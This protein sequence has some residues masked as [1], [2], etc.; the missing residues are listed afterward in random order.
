MSLPTATGT[1]S[2]PD[3]SLAP[4]GTSSVVEPSRPASV[5]SPHPRKAATLELEWR[6]PA[7]VF[8]ERH[9]R[10]LVAVLLL[11]GVAL[12]FFP[13]L[14]GSAYYSPEQSGFH[15][16]EPKLVRWMDDLPESFTS[17][18]DYR[19]P[20][21]L[22]IAFGALWLPTR[23]ALGLD[24]SG[25]S[26]VGEESY[27]AAQVFGR[28]LNVLVFGLGGVLLIWSFTRRRYGAGPAVL[29]LAA[30]STM[31]LPV[32][33]SALMLPDIAAAVLLFA[34]F[35]QLARV[36]ARED[37][38]MRGFLFAGALL[39]AATA[40]K[41]TSAIGAIGVLAVLVSEV[42][43]RRLSRTQA[44][45]VGL[46]SG[47]C[48]LG[49]FLLF[50][51]GVWLDPEAFFASISYEFRSKLVTSQ[52]RLENLPSS[53]LRSFPAPLMA[54]AVLGLVRARR[55]S[56]VP[57]G[58]RSVALLSAGA[59][60]SIYLLISLRSFRPDYVLPLFPFVAVFAGVGLWQLV[61]IPTRG[62]GTLAV[63][64]GLVLGLVQTATWVEQRY[65]RDTRYVFEEWVS[66]NLP[67]GPIGI[68][69][70]AT[71][72]SSGA[73][74]PAGYSYVD[75]RSFPEYIVVFQRRADQ[76]LEFLEDPEALRQKTERVWGPQRALAE[77]VT[78]PGERRLGK[79]NEMQLSFYEDLL[80]G[81]RRRWRYDLVK[82]IVP[83]AAP[84][85]LPGRK[86]WIYRSSARAGQG[87]DV[88][89][90]Q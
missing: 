52:L 66:E 27:E 13:L 40:T 55:W 84:L 14:W 74:A 42:V 19:Y 12:R 36:E 43:Q 29:A 16:D 3:A 57:A 28:T 21:L 53:F 20:P 18:T 50:V 73:A 31:G 9:E 51:P 61:R 56:R 64:A 62:V 1:R 75:V 87:A 59:A 11:I 41:Y 60:L 8:V 34:V 47:V 2:E 68:A 80:L 32:T 82:E 33:S 58:R 38:K 89:G 25:K 15:P 37:A 77:I 72:R 44:A 24:D 65:S 39:G 81:E 88:A 23:A 67:P 76:V 26:T 63:V 54:V 17:Y 4:Q 5:W 10:K 90:A 45:S 69:P 71:P 49:V 30:A 35:V 83:V 78:T 22:P 86:V 79:L 70:S 48:A 46:A 6:S 7:T 85:D